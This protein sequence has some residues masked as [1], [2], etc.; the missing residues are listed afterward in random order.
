MVAR[1]LLQS[2]ENDKLN[3]NQKIKMID[4]WYANRYNLYV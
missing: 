2:V 4:N 1:D 3:V